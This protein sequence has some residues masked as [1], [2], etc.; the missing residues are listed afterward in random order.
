MLLI[1]YLSS[2]FFFLFDSYLI[3]LKMINHLIYFI[4][5]YFLM[6]FNKYI[7]VLL[8]NIY[9]FLVKNCIYIYAILIYIFYILDHI[10]HIYNN[11]ILLNIIFHIMCF[12]I[13]RYNYVDPIYI[14]IYLYHRHIYVF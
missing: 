12:I 9:I 2:I 4:L 13:D 6:N 8:T 7:Y 5:C 11:D 14:F 1:I 3:I 10:N